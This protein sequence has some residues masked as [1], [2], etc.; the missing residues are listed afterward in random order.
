MAEPD[1]LIVKP[2]PNMAKDGLGAAF[3]FFYIE[4]SKNEATLRKFFPVDKG[5]I[6]SIDPIG[7]SPVI[8]EKV[9]ILHH[10]VVLAKVFF[11]ELSLNGL[12]HLLKR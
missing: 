8:I 1:H 12:R 3:P 7:N 4:P 11:I 9:N 5:P 10:T 6:T 2:I